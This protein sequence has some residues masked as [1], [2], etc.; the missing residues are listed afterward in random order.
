[1]GFVI[2]N[3]TAQVE[4]VMHQD[5]SL[6]VNIKAFNNLYN[7]RTQLV[8]LRKSKGLTQQDI[9]ERSGLTQ[10]MISKV[11]KIENGGTIDTFLKYAHA[12]G[13]ELYIK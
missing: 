3:T 2:C 1:M 8:S 11:E 6:S 12:L 4:E 13:V 9:A 5:S 10:Q 7:L